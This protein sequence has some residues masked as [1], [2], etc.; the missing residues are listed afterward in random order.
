[1]QMDETGDATRNTHDSNGCLAAIGTAVDVGV[2]VVIRCLV[3]RCLLLLLFGLK[4][5]V[6]MGN[7]E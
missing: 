2:G 3:R 7:I 5:A 4:G 6:T 1:M